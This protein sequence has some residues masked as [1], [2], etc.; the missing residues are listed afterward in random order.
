MGFVY[1]VVQR[2]RGKAKGRLVSKQTGLDFANG[3]A[4]FPLMIMACCALSSE[5]IKSLVEASKISL[6]IA[7]LFA[8]IAILEDNDDNGSMFR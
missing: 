2:C 5:L 3:T 6:S 7:G 1:T 4:L 8:L